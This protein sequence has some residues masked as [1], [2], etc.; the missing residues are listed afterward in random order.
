ML[1]QVGRLGDCII[2][3]STTEQERRQCS[4]WEGDMVL[5]THNFDSL[6]SYGIDD[7]WSNSAHLK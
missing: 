1:L 5:I 4:K 7:N 3:R 6:C 2:F